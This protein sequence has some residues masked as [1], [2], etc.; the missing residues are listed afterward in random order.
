MAPMTLRVKPSPRG[1]TMPTDDVLLSAA[2]D[3]QL[4]DEAARRGL[5]LHSTEFSRSTQ[6][7]IRQADKLAGDLKRLRERA[8]QLERMKRN[9]AD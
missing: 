3:Q 2:T 4:R 9:H 8:E 1:P 5:V 6:D 7:F